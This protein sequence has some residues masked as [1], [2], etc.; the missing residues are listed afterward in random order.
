MAL[1]IQ[2][3]P[4]LLQAFSLK[5]LQDLRGNYLVAN[6]EYITLPLDEYFSGPSLDYNI[7]PSSPNM[8]LANSSLNLGNTTQLISNFTPPKHMPIR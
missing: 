6:N 4:L 2:L 7:S 5:V 8:F 1:I 3:L